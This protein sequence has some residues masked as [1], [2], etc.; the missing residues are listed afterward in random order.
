MVSFP[1]VSPGRPYTPPSP[2]PYGP[3][4]QPISFFSIL[5]PAQYWVRSTFVKHTNHGPQPDKEFILTFREDRASRYILTIKPTRCTNISNSFYFWI[6]T[7]HVSDS[8]SVHHQESSTVHT[9]IHT[10]YADCLLAR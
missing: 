8:F 9:A 4:A 10:G 3:H 1:P 5:L 6:R 7:L 2:H